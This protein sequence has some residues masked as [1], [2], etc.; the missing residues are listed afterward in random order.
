MPKAISLRRKTIDTNNKI[1][2]M[3]IS[4]VVLILAGIAVFL[5]L[6]TPQ[7]TTV[8]Q[9][10]MPSTIPA[11][12]NY[13]APV[14]SLQNVNGKTESLQDYRDKIV[15]VNNWAIWCPP[16]KEE[17][18]TLEAYYEAH[19]AEGFVIIG[20]EAGEAQA[21]VLKYAQ[22][23]EMT[24]P[25]WFD[26]KYAALAAF[27]TQGLPNSYVIDRKGKVRLVWIGEISGDVLEKYVTPLLKNNY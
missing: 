25:V 16:C 9:T 26:T 23:N 2:L 24:Y 7:N 8:T 20:I 18:P 14:L 11:K 10:N 4:G 12:V 27:R 5:L 13:P 17:I 6:Q 21:D 19:S 3:S 1:R 22:A 15:L